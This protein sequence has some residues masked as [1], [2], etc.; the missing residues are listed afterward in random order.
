MFRKILF[1]FLFCLPAV[2][3][4]FTADSLTMYGPQNGVQSQFWTVTFSGYTLT[5]FTESLSGFPCVQCQI[6][7]TYT[8]R[9]FTPGGSFF[10]TTTFGQNPDYMEMGSDFEFGSTTYTI[11]NVPPG[12]FTVTAPIHLTGLIRQND[13][14]IG[15]DL[16]VLIDLD[17]TVTYSFYYSY[18]E[19]W[20]NDYSYTFTRPV[21]PSE[22][23]P[24]PASVVLLASGV[25]GLIGRRRIVPKRA[26]R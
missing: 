22:P 23:V 19:V 20:T 17:G 16:L 9:S 14:N 10:G 2:A 15:P 12:T 11:P 1:F 24:E 26:A 21:P 13:E 25:A 7:E 6:G 4:T 8:S 18:G 5:G 3:D